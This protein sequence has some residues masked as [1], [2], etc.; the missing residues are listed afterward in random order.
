MTWACGSSNRRVPPPGGWIV[1]HGSGGLSGLL[2]PPRPHAS[3]GNIFVLISNGLRH[4]QEEDRTG[5]GGG[6]CADADD[7]PEPPHPRGHRQ[8]PPQPCTGPFLLPH[9]VTM[10]LEGE[11]PLL[12]RVKG[13]QQ[14]ARHQNRQRAKPR[15]VGAQPPL[16]YVTPLLR[17]GSVRM[18]PAVDPSSAHYD[19]KTRSMRGNP[20]AEVPP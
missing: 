13:A 16:P 7:D 15:W 10:S 8:V 12:P 17:Q 20:N 19:P 5:G 14:F 1:F 18:A 6:G 4:P 2:L 3:M 9:P 11:R